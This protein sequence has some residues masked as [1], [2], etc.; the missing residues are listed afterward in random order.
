M[1]WIKFKIGII[2]IVDFR[3]RNNI[4]NVKNVNVVNNV[5]FLYIFF[6]NFYRYSLYVLLWYKL[7][8][9]EIDKKDDSVMFKLCFWCIF[10]LVLKN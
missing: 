5:V 8:Y 6:D 10:G 1:M 2:I 7:I 4:W 3:F 9:K